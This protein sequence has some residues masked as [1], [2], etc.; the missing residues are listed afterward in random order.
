M[1]QGWKDIADGFGSLRAVE[2]EK[3]PSVPSANILH[4]LILLVDEEDYFGF[5]EQIYLAREDGS[6]STIC[7]NQ[8]WNDSLTDSEI[9]Q[10]ICFM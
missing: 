9:N 3:P 8:G 4:S 5:N 1:T 7:E 10:D 2:D 6:I